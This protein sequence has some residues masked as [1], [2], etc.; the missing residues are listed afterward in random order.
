MSIQFRLHIYTE[1]DAFGQEGDKHERAAEVANILR[2]VA[3]RL[4][5]GE[6]FAPNYETLHDANGNDVGRAAFKFI[7]Q[8]ITANGDMTT[9]VALCVDAECPGEAKS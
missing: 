7:H 4:D 6:P 9:S 8:H 5:A 2:A 1:N 3:G